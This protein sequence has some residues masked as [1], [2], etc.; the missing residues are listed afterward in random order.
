V[1]KK[2][3]IAVNSAWNIF[4]FRAGLIRALVSRGLEVIVIA[5]PDDYVARVQGLGCRF[6]ALPMDNQGTHPGRDLVLLWN[7]HRLLR[8][9]RPAAFLGYTVKPNVYGSLAAH[10]LRIPV[11]NNIAGLGA[12]FIHRGILSRLVGLLYRLALGRS[13]CVLFQN[14]DDRRMFIDRGWVR[15]ERTDRIPGSGINL[16]SFHYTEALPLQGRPFRFL[17]VARM[18]WDKGVGEY[19]EAAR[20]LRLRGADL[21]FQLLGFLDVQNPAAITREQVQAWV[22]EGVVTYLGATDDVRPH[23]ARS[24]CVVLP[25]YREGLPHTLLEAMATGRPIIATDTAGCRDLVQHEV[26]G[27]LCRAHDVNHLAEVM[28]RM[29]ELPEADRIIMGRR[30]REKAQRDFDEEV[31]IRRYLA[32]VENETRQRDR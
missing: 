7:F 32:L 21:E 24:D 30:G 20:Q 26:N 14:E 17:L 19:V 31:V 22:R 9:E 3:A 15:A 8:R 23:I 11:I 4:N 18:L 10:A 5:P 28:Q 29:S 13:R 27:Y 6:V 25:S 12:V 16:A 2:V 1:A